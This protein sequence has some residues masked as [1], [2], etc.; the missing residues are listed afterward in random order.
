LIYHDVRQTCTLSYGQFLPQS[1]GDPIHDEST[2]RLMGQWHWR[3]SQHL[4]HF[5]SLFW[6]NE[7]PQ[8]QAGRT[9]HGFYALT[10]LQFTF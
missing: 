7:V 3:C 1:I 6:E 8:A 5:T 2:H 10:G 4:S 9:R